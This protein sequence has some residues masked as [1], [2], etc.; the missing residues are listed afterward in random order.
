MSKRKTSAGVGLMVLLCAAW[1]VPAAGPATTKAA[2]HT[3]ETQPTVIL[4]TSGFWRMHHTLKPPVVQL[5]DGPKAALTGI[6][7]L[8]WE[9]PPP[10]ED[11]TKA[12]FDDHW[13]ARFPLRRAAITPY[14]ARLCLR[15]KFTVTA[16]AKVRG[17][18]LLLDYHGGAIVYVNGKE[19]ARGNVPAGQSELAEGY[20]EEA[21]IDAKGELLTSG[22]S[23]DAEAKRRIGL[24]TRKLAAVPVPADCLRTGVNVLAI[25]IVRAPYHKV[26]TTKKPL[27]QRVYYIRRHPY[28]L[29]WSTCHIDRVQL[30]ANTAEGLVPNCTRPNGLQVWNSD[31]LAGD[32]DLD[33][34]DTCEELRAIHLVGA[35]NGSYSGK[36]V[37]GSTKPIMELKAA[38]SDL[39]GSR[40][41]VPSSAVHLRYGIRWGQEHAVSMPYAGS[42]PYPA[43]E[44]LLGALAEKPLAEFPVQ[45]KP[46]ARNG[47]KTPNQPALVAGAVTSIWATVRVP[48]DAKPGVYRGKITIR[49][50]GHKPVNAPIELKVLD[51]SLPDPQDYKTWIEFIQSP[52]TLSVEYGIEPWSDRHWKM[53]AQSFRYLNE[54][55]S[56]TAYVPV[57]AQTNLGN[58]HSMV[59]W[60]RKGENKF[61]FDF[62]VMDKY[63][64]IAA[65]NMGKPKI[66]CFVVWDISLLKKELHDLGGTVAGKARKALAGKGPLV[67]VVD[68]AT[69][70]LENIHLPLFT[71]AASGEIWK[72]LF[73]EIRSR[74]KARGLDGATA[75]G[76][77]SDAQ[78]TKEQAQF[79]QETSGGLPWVVHAHQPCLQLQGIGKVAYHVRVWG[80]AYPNGGTSLFGWKGD[81]LGAQF[82][83]G[84]Q[85]GA[86]AARWRHCA[87][88]NVAG[89]QRGIGRLGADFWYAVKDKKGRR[90]GT[91]AGRY[92]QSAWANLDLL[93]HFLAPGPDGPV[94][95]NRFEAVRE[96]VQECEARIYLETALTDKALRAK[97]GEELAGRIKQL[98]DE[99]ILY[100]WKNFSNLRITGRHWDWA[101]FT[102]WRG[103]GAPGHSWFL[104]TGWQ[105]RSEKLYALAAEVQ[106]KLAER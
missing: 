52:D 12:D 87:E 14:L 33:F 36:V 49:A 30:A 42:W 103:V 16:P 63:I 20:P 77:I 64:D 99:R 27:D 2:A 86:A 40:G 104:G 48:A 74:M 11:W 60:I 25:D 41:T 102:P 56:R 91:V 10:S 6:K 100:M 46:P 84:D 93:S 31:P 51:W 5:D 21:F 78:P 67:T 34:G 79:L 70:K 72:P 24:R 90:V 71:D 43:K 18:S 58:E 37:V 68:P 13:W 54:I 26:V 89:R 53:I 8:D 97:L 92:P 75:L 101:F 88:V 98:L 15:G 82:Q 47:L 96:G 22:S 81:F 28:D 106:K 45:R 94:V 50:Q 7:W 29:N 83:R 35:R 38:A 59:R 19:I 4:D 57:I 85:N 17:L 105:Q 1:S 80:N 44:S 73:A 39:K 32:F 62:S 23:G 69:R 66:V 76:F 61:D 9:T 55:G 3:G 65:K 95:T